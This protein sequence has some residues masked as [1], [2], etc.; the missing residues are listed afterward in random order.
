MESPS[1]RQA[2]ASGEGSAPSEFEITEAM[3][4]AAVDAMRPWFDQVG[5][6][7]AGDIRPALREA[8]GKLYLLR[9]A[10]EPEASKRQ[11]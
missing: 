9:G 1:T 2:C 7:D 5:C 8:M 3:I 6:L 10:G 11:R 4:D